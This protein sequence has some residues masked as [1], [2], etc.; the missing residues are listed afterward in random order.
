MKP[1]RSHSPEKGS[2]DVKERFLYF[3]YFRSSPDAADRRHRIGEEQN[4]AKTQRTNGQPGRDLHCRLLRSQSKRDGSELRASADLVQFDELQHA[5]G[6]RWSAG[7]E[8]TVRRSKRTVARF[9]GPHSG[10]CCSG[11]HAGSRWCAGE[12]VCKTEAEAQRV[13]WVD[14]PQCGHGVESY[15]DPPGARKVAEKIRAA[16]GQID[17]VAMDEPLY[18][19]HYYNGRDACHSSIENVAER[20]AAIMREYQNAFPNAMIGDIEPFPAITNQPN[21]QAEYKAWMQAFSRATGQNIA[22]L[23]VDINWRQDNANWRQSLRQIA[24]FAQA[25]HLPLG[26]IYNANMTPS[27]LS[28]QAW[29]N[30]ALQNTTEIE[31]KMGIVPAQ[32]IFHSW[33]KFPRR[34]ITDETGLGEDYL[35]KQ[36]LM[37]HKLQ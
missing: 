2:T 7:L 25:S 26:I 33:D 4:A 17:M 8:E 30:S 34:S 24:S 28:D 15:Y 13:R 18:Y 37:G 19:G 36:Y 22:F 6:R 27:I 11:H 5:A 23:H 31:N 16:G 35:V 1:V 29:L 21:W 20:A 9:H 12:D 10:R 14:E 32:A 3:A